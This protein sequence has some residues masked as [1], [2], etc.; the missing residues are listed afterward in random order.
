MAA[1][2]RIQAFATGS[3]RPEVV[4]RVCLKRLFIA[5]LE[6]PQTQQRSKAVRSNP[7]VRGRQMMVHELPRIS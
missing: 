1:S 3:Y 5:L 7:C 4:N 6:L 2:G